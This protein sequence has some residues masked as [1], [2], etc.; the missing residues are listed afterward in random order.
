LKP[1][2]VRIDPQRPKR[3][4]LLDPRGAEL[5]VRLWLVCVRHET[6]LSQAFLT[7]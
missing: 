3:L 1:V 7:G 2:R 4:Q 6:L 5:I